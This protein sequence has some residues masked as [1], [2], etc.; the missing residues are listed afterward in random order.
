MEI[1]RICD[2]GDISTLNNL[3]ISNRLPNPKL[4]KYYYEIA[5]RH[6][7]MNGNVE[8]LKLIID[9]SLYPPSGQIFHLSLKQ[10]K[11]SLFLQ[12]CRCNQTK[13]VEY[14][15]TLTGKNKINIGIYD[16]AYLRYAT[17]EMKC[18]IDKYK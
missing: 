5:L 4:N 16:N 9:Y 1:I 8:I 12:A 7:A 13:I 11:E 18:I 10:V 6:A 14:L 17:D 2:E 15:L 3:I